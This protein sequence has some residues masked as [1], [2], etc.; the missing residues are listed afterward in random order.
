[1]SHP[2]SDANLRA[3]QRAAELVTFAAANFKLKLD[4]SEESIARVEHTLGEIHKHFG[5]N[6]EQ[7]K[8]AM[9]NLANGFGS[10]IGE[11]I[12]RNHGGEWRANLPNLPPGVDGLYVNGAVVSP[13]QAVFLRITKG[14]QFNIENFYKKAQSTILQSRKSGDAAPAPV[15][16]PAAGMAKS[17]AEAVADAKLLFGIELDYSEATLDRLDDALRRLH[18]VLTDKVPESQRMDNNEEFMLKPVAALRYMAY[19]GE[20]FRKGLGAEW[21]NDLNGRQLTSAG[22]VYE[23]K[24][25][26][27]AV[28]GKVISP[29]QIIV[30]CI[31]DPESWSAKN[32]YL[33]AK[34]TIQTNSAMDKAE[35]FSDRMGVVAQEAVTIARDRYAVIL[36]FSETSVASLEGLL[37]QLHEQLPK[38]GD[39]NRPSGAWIAGISITFGAYLGEIFRKNLGGKWIPQNPGILDS[40]PALNIQGN[41]LTPC[42]KVSKRI[43]H[44][45]GESV[46]F[47]Y[48][49]ASKFIREGLATSKP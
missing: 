36:D 35:S 37:S 46:E 29:G 42:S 30:N 22:L 10:Y 27:A 38:L 17:A 13:L 45:P 4:Y 3:N 12:R 33:D 43:L 5:A 16:D 44:G 1:M 2:Q 31:N 23:G 24:L 21:R 40:L 18:E 47:F 41:V 6:A 11:V 32:Y 28:R 7:N 8:A 14:S 25:I 39:P 26:E 48:K 15:A 34:R 49:A 20:V 19:L 9:V